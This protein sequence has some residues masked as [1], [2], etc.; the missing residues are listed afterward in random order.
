MRQLLFREPRGGATDATEIHHR[1]QRVERRDGLHRI[2]RAEPRQQ[3]RDGARLDIACAQVGDRQRAGA[4]AE[5]ATL[6]VD[7]QW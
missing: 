2:G 3:R 6:R 1:H 5:A 4:L 7:Q